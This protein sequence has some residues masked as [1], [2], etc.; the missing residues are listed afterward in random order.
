MQQAIVRVAGLEKLLNLDGFRESMTEIK[1]LLRTQAIHQYGANIVDKYE[2]G[3]WDISKSPVSSITEVGSI[4]PTPP[5]PPTGPPPTAK[6]TASRDHG[7]SCLF[8][9]LFTYS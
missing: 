6:R 7:L 1:G 4:S 8:V 9:C 3:L 5:S 2:L